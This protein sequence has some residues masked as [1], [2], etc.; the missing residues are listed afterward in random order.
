MAITYTYKIIRIDT[1]ETYNDLA[2][3]VKDIE[4]EYEGTQVDGAF[5]KTAK[6]TFSCELGDPDSENFKTYA[7]LTEADVIGFV[8]KTTNIDFNKSVI[9]SKLALQGLPDK[10]VKDL[11]WA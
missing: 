6:H 5:S 8:E 9:G 2:D 10:V 4:F 7:D 3:V 1:Y 11:P